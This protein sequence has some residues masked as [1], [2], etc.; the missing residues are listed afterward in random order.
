MTQN[1]LVK[2]LKELRNTQEGGN[3]AAQE[4]ERVFRALMLQINQTQ[5]PRQS[6]GSLGFV[7]LIRYFKPAQFIMPMA[8]FALIV[9]AS[10]AFA[11]S[12]TA[13]PGQHLYGAKIA[14]DQT[15]VRFVSNPAE[16]AKVQMEMAGRRL[17]EAGQVSTSPE[18]TAQA[19]KHFS[20]GVKDA[21]ESLQEAG[22]P[23]Q[24]E[25]AAAELSKKARQYEETLLKTKQK[26]A[27]ERE[28]GVAAIKEAE[29]A[30]HEVT[31]ATDVPEHE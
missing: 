20:Q 17:E 28:V 19:L 9:A 23:L 3:P 6:I 4:K 22:D 26:V 11:A 2:K 25:S 13:L 27:P 29:E 16:R 31:E 24:V 7:G 5:S 14:F 21:R 10:S 18:H 8:V 12:R 30:L 1:D 15:Q